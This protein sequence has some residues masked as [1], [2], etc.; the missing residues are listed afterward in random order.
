MPDP[1]AVVLIVVFLPWHALAPDPPV[2][3]DMHTAAACQDER[4]REE[5][6][7]RWKIAH[8]PAYPYRWVHITCERRS[9]A[10]T[11]RH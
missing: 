3:R 10:M 8:D 9:E 5:Q 1:L 11:G 7:A 6:D 2:R 4:R